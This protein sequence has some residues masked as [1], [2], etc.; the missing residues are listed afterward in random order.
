MSSVDCCLVAES[1]GGASC[2]VFGDVAWSVVDVVAAIVVWV[3]V[4]AVADAVAADVS[5]IL[6]RSLL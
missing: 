4:A 6:D 2:E 3:S 1:A 5:V